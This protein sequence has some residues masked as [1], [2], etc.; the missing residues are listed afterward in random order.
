MFDC[1]LGKKKIKLRKKKV[2]FLLVSFCHQKFA[3]DMRNVFLLHTS[4]T[5]LA[6]FSGGPGVS[7]LEEIIKICSAGSASK[8]SVIA[9]F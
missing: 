3:G 6:A 4:I 5:Q 2:V 9:W 8:N 1:I 7:N